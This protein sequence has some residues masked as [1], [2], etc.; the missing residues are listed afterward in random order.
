MD[1]R[2]GITIAVSL[3]FCIVWSVLTG[4]YYKKRLIKWQKEMEQKNQNLRLQLFTSQIRP[5]FILN[6]L[7]AIRNKRILGVAAYHS[8]FCRKCG[9]AWSHGIEKRR[10]NLDPEQKSGRP[11]LR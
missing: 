5:H 1:V 11:C 3:A 10:D 7:R 8:A 9:K 2:I 4:I 6:T